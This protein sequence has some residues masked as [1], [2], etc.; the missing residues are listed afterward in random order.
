MLVVSG[1]AG[2]CAVELPR[3]YAR[4]ARRIQRNGKIV[5]EGV[6]RSIS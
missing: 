5:E 4:W 1:M 6:S 2:S 3:A